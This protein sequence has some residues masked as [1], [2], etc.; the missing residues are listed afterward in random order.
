MSEQWNV[1]YEEQAAWDKKQKEFIEKEK[2]FT[3]SSVS[4]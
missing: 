1:I 3:I 2:K 4:F